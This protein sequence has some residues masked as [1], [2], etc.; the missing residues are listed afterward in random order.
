MSQ[1]F[2][3]LIIKVTQVSEVTLFSQGNGESWQGG[4]YYYCCKLLKLAPFLFPS[5]LLSKQGTKTFLREANDPALSVMARFEK[6]IGEAQD[7]ICQAIEVADSGAKF[8]K[9]VWSRAGGGGGISRV[10]Q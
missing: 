10:L 8:R 2:R 4:C 9:D 1:I 3:C 7:T 6:M 5:S